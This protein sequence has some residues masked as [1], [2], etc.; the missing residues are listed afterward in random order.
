MRLTLKN[1]KQHENLEI[2]IPDKGLVRLSGV[3]GAGKSAIMEAIQ[4]GLWGG[5][6]NIVTWGK[7]ASQVNIEDFVGMNI[8]RTRSPVS[9]SMSHNNLILQDSAAQAHI[10]NILGMTEY[11]FELCSYIKQRQTNSFLSLGPSDKMKL[12]QKIAFSDDSSVRVQNNI[13]VKI[14][15]LKDKL[16]QIE[17]KRS[18]L[19]KQSQDENERL[20]SMVMNLGT[21]PIPP[22]IPIDNPQSRINAIVSDLRMLQDRVI[23]I[24]KILSSG[25]Y[26]LP[27]KFASAQ[28]EI[29]YEIAKCESQIKGIEERLSVMDKPFASLSKA[30]CDDKIW[31]LRDHYKHRQHAMQYKQ[32]VEQSYTGIKN[33]LKRDF[34]RTEVEPLIENYRSKVEA[35]E[36]EFAAKAI[37]LKQLDIKDLTC[38]HCNN[39][40]H[41]KDYT[42]VPSPDPTER[43]NEIKQLQE[44]SVILSERISKGRTVVKELTQHFNSYIGDSITFDSVK[45]ELEIDPESIDSQMQALEVYSAQQNGI[46]AEIVS[47]NN[48]LGMLNRQKNDLLLRLSELDKKLQDTEKL[49]EIPIETLYSELEARTEDISSK[50]SEL[51]LL[52]SYLRELDNFNNTV[53]RKYLESVSAI[54]NQK[55]RVEIAVCNYKSID[56]EYII[57]QKKYS[58]LI[59]LKQIASIASLSALE[60]TVQA[61]NSHVQP[62]LTHMFPESGTSVTL[63]TKRLKTDGDEKLEVS[64]SISHKGSDKAKRIEDLSGGEQSRLILAYQLALSEMFNSP[65]L[66]IDEGFTGLDSDTQTECLSMLAPIAERKLVLVVEHNTSDAIF[67][68]CIEI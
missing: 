54:N 1:I 61:I 3:S 12:L 31:Q 65:I 51:V 17:A 21:E 46:S 15:V 18:L 2:S 30:E 56:S 10:S 36:S 45:H 64:V 29:G 13:A 16:L 20:S 26:D 60:Y 57:A 24:N 34:E 7:T 4:E 58:S 55:E 23:E 47:M 8:T 50:Q 49:R 63:Q 22:T 67:D 43:A 68:H 9:C 19:S 32:F 33:I 39:P 14:K 66:M 27:K 42:L 59:N 5:A 35:L 53:M 41:I 38:P 52:Q 37:R 62:F 48:M 28:S 6:R 44:Q 40:V 11:E 25:A